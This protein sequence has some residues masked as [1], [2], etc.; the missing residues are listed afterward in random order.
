M[1]EQKKTIEA[2]NNKI[3]QLQKQLELLLKEVQ[4]LK[5][6]SKE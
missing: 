6:R 2:Q 5:G 4:Q 3:D 1:Q